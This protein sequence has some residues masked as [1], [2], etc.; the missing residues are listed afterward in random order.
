MTLNGAYASPTASQTGRL[1]DTYLSETA[2]DFAEFLVYC[3]AALLLTWADEMKGMEFKVRHP[4]RLCP[5]FPGLPLAASFTP[6]HG[7]K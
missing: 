1:W 7:T 6:H 4:S 5:A 2:A 3:G